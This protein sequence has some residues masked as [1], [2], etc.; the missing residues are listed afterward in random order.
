MDFKTQKA[1]Q[2]QEITAQHRLPAHTPL[3]SWRSE[4]AAREDSQSESILILDGMWQFALFDSINSVPEVWPNRLPDMVPI[5][6][7]GHWQLQGFDYPIYTNVRYPFPCDPPVVPDLNPT[8]CYL[9]EFVLPKNWATDDQIRIIFDGVD[10]AFHLWCN[11][12]WIGYSQDSRL[13]AEFDLTQNLKQGKNVLSVMVIR[14]CDGSYLEGQDMWNLSGIYRSVRLLAKPYSRITDLRINAGLNDNYTD[15]LLSL[16][17]KT[18]NAEECSVRVALY[19]E[20]NAE[21]GQILEQIHPLGTRHI[22]EKGAYK[23]RCHIAMKIPAAKQWSAEKP[24]LYRL[25][26]TLL[27]P[28]LKPIES[29]GYDVGFRSVDIIAGQLCINGKP[30]LIR[31]V[32]KHEHDPATGHTET[33][34]L[35]EQDL[36]LMKQN[37]FNAVRCS[38]YP[39]QPGFY[40]LCDR[41]GI[42]VVDE[43]NI[44]THGV[45]PMSRLADDPVWA[46]AFLER[47]MRMVARDFNHPCVIVW[48]LGNESGYGAAHDAMY[49]WTKREDPSRPIQYEGGGSNTYATDIICPM[50]ARTDSDTLQHPDLGDKPSLKK[51]IGFVNENRPIILCEYAHAMGNSLGNFSDYWDMFRTHPRIQGG[52]IWDWVDQGLNKTDE[53]GRHYWGYGGDFGDAINDGQFCI[54]GLVYPDRTSHPALLEAKRCQQPFTARL[55]ESAGVEVTLQSEHLFLTCENETLNWEFS[56]KGQIL[57]EGSLALAL[58]PGAKGKFSLA[59]TPPETTQPCWLNLWITQNTATAWCDANHEIAR[60]QFSLP[61]QIHSRPAVKVKFAEIKESDIDYKIMAAENLWQINRNTGLVESWKKEGQ[62]QLIEPLIDNFFRAPLDN[63]IGTSQAHKIDQSSWRARWKLAGIFALE[64]RCLAITAD[65]VAGLIEVEHGYY[66]K[67]KLQI[68]TSWQHRFFQDGQMTVL[69]DVVV[70][71]DMPPLPRVGASLRSANA[72]QKVNWFGLGPHENYPDRK[73]S[74]DFAHWQQ[75]IEDL[76]TN[77]IFPSENGLR[78]EVSELTLGDI[79]VRGKFHF[80]VSRYGQR[81]LEAATHTHQLSAVDGF[82]LYIDGFHMGV[83]G[84][85]SWTPSV[86]LPYQLNKSFYQ[87]GFSLK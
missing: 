59:S 33:L 52:F 53:Q 69:I 13:P 44:E 26:A 32:N 84:D 3:C 5:N 87:W 29:E 55:H 85:D 25:I 17:I 86:K 28:E 49:Q 54:N 66:Q 76:H 6:V 30:L 22:D 7:P 19:D 61:T 27:D 79:E 51:W 24:Y 78:C 60:W 62:Q 67:D 37:N 43:A 20:E 73:A 50:Y 38:H 23:D 8:G 18:Y 1:W 34:Q 57:A 14:R 31:G 58:E 72:V 70:A 4:H 12:S 39:H 11:G 64:H 35:V 80:S 46:N 65:N 9:R 81:Q 83:G 77:Y 42:Y 48:S 45:T 41:L 15:G 71:G 63:D 82:Y 10:S 74:V 75:S 21:E 2:T 16:E 47:M 68:K 40:R 36:R 56:T